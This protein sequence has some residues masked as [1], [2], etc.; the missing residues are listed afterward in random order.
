[1][2]IVVT[3]GSGFIGR[4]LVPHLL[5]AGH[6]VVV[7][8]RV[9]YRGTGDPEVVLGDLLEPET[10]LRAIG[11]H[12]DAVVHL[13]ALTSVLKSRENPQAVYDHNVAMT[14][15]LLERARVLGVR[16]FA[17]AST[18]AVA[19]DCGYA[20]IDEKTPV[21]PLTPYGATKAAAEM[22][23][24]GYARAYGMRCAVLRITNAYGP[25]MEMK[26]SVVPRFV[27]AILHR[28]PA[29]IYGDGSQVRDFVFTADIAEAFRRAVEQEYSGV[30]TIGRGQSLSI[31]ELVQRLSEAA[32]APLA[33]EHVPAK[34]GEMPAVIVSAQ[35]A[36]RELGWQARVGIDEGLALVWEDLKEKLAPGPKDTESR[37]P[38]G[39][40]RASGSL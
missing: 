10:V 39:Q 17:F 25:G 6:R 16:R 3:G 12:V 34:A 26:D 19:G 14:Q 32:S 31:L 29:T 18:N 28:Q 36:L 30:L 20:V 4:A 35:K 27:R 5:N 13:A 23:L 9:P 22:L 33:V 15:A 21:A 24:G 40:K 1:M 2:R 8:D 7:A 11:E 38:T 37:S